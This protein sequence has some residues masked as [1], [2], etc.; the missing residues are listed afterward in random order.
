MFYTFLTGLKDSKKNGTPHQNGPVVRNGSFINNNNTIIKNIK[1][2]TEFN[3]L[4]IGVKYK[5]KPIIPEYL[6]SKI[7]AAAVFILLVLNAVGS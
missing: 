4:N 1:F 6:I 2:F 7:N 5:I 3:L